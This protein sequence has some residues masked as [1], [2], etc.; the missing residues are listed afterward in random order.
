M[1]ILG[2]VG[3]AVCTVLAL[4]AV[5]NAQPGAPVP[6]FSP[7]ESFDTHP[8]G[9]IDEGESVG[10]WDVVWDGYGTVEVTGGVDRRLSLVPRVVSDPLDTASALVV[11]SERLA[12][13]WDVSARVGLDEQIRVGSDA[14]TWESPWLVWSYDDND[15]YYLAVKTNGWEVGAHVNDPDPRQVFL[16][17]GDAPGIA[18]GESVMVRVRDDGADSLVWV[19]GVLVAQVDSFASIADGGAGGVGFYTEDARITVDDVTVRS[20]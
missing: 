9:V 16:A 17:T 20:C 13:C 3:L 8:V 14:N 11:S 5:A 19:D 18:E 15:F 7:M 1:K 12:G 4:P 10:D 6:G 2:A